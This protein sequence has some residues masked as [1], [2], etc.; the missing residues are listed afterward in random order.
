MF[1]SFDLVVVNF[2]FVHCHGLSIIDFEQVNLD[3]V[4][5]HKNSIATFFLA[6]LRAEFYR[7]S[8]L[9]GS[10][11]EVF[12]LKGVLTPRQLWH[13]CFTL[14]FAKFLRISLFVEHLRQ[15]LLHFVKSICA[16]PFK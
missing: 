4:S 6:I 3:Y 7:R 2:N 11:P 12:C 1:K 10:C 9:R 5:A 16:N 8:S 15:L 13:R 14:S